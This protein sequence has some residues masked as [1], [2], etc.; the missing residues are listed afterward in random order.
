MGDVGYG[1]GIGVQGI[2]E[3]FGLGELAY[4]NK[5]WLGRILAGFAGARAAIPNQAG[6][7]KTPRKPN[8]N[9]VKAGAAAAIQNQ[10]NG[11]VHIA[12]DFIAQ[13]GRDNGQQILNDMA[14]ASASNGSR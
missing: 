5:S 9:D 14:F 1:S 7:T 12:G 13:A 10:T 6:E 8:M 11:G 3:T 4:P 2:I